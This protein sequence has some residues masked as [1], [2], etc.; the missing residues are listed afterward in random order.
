MSFT[1]VEE[2]GRGGMGVVWR[3]RDDE[4]GQV[5]ALKL[6]RDLYVEDESYRLRFEHELEIARRINSPHVVKVLGYGARDGVPY[7]AFEFVDGPSLRQLIISHGPY[8]WVDVRLMLLQLAEGLADAHAA[9]VIHRD[10]KPSN[11]LVDAAG[12]AKLADF[13][14]SRALDVTRVTKASGLL[15]T[16]AYLAPEGPVDARSDL[17]SLGVLAFELLVGSPPF[18][19]GTYHEVLVAHLRRQPDLSKVPAEARPLV[20]WLLAKEPDA[21][22][23][24]ARQLIRV[25]TGAE[26]IPVPPPTAPWPSVPPV[27]PVWPGGT[28]SRVA[29]TI[30]IAGAIGAVVLIVGVLLAVSVSRSTGPSSNGQMPTNGP[31]ATHAVVAA[32]A[33]GGG[34]SQPTATLVAAAGSAPL[35]T[36]GSTSGQWFSSGSLPRSVWGDGVAQLPDGRVEIF[37]SCAGDAAHTALLDTWLL[38]AQTGSVVDG[39]AMVWSQSVPAIAAFDDGKAVMVAG[40]WSG[41]EPTAQAELLDEATG[42]FVAVPSMLT[43]RSQATATDIGNGRVLVA[44]GWISHDSNG[45]TATASAEIFDRS[46]GDWSQAAPMSTP[47]ALATAT[48]LQDGRVLMVGGDR[49]WAGGDDQSAAQQV[50]NSAETYDPTTDTWQDAGDMSVPR[51]AQ[52]A[53]LLANGHVLVAGGWSDG[54]E[55]G[56]SSAEEYVPGG[57]WNAVGSMPSAHAQGRLVALEDGRM[58]EVGGVDGAG[59][60]TSE[61]DLYDPNSGA[62]QRTGSLPQAVYWPAVT[63]LSDG[64]VLAVGGATDSQVIGQL[65]TYGP[66]PRH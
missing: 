7:I 41:S 26:G 47:R 34:G 27:A 57:G 13:G 2:I 51:A 36:P 23:Q 59:K 56:L 4:T 38:N 49:S 6:L 37:S 10:V 33:A 22:P 39:P 40:G 3:A 46:T 29:P 24:S 53:A 35:A 48:R 18:E 58:L 66:P 44:G 15:G 12:T 9:G 32:S 62:W 28:R 30:A 8:P 21:R 17:Y 25:L 52:S 11:V 61:T 65:E 60:A 1:L 5:V 42:S 19:G 55:S 43:P 20:S 63:V 54:S 31:T 64:R 16:P 50:L 14:I 45:Y